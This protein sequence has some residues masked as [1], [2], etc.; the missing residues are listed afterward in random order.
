MNEKLKRMQAQKNIIALL[1]EKHGLQ[2]SPKIQEFSLLNLRDS[3]NSRLEPNS[4][5]NAYATNELSN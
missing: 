5:E 4:A 2:D 3:N 1:A